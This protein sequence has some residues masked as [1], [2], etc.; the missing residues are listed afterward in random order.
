MGKYKLPV[1][2]LGFVV[3]TGALMGI[4]ALVPLALGLSLFIPALAY[5]VS[6]D[7][8]VSL[9]LGI[10]F[11][12]LGAVWFL[13]S[14]KIAMEIAS[15]PLFGILARIS[16][17][18]LKTEN[19]ILVLSFISFGMTVIEDFFVGLP[20]EVQTLTWFLKLKWGLYFFSSVVISAIS[21]GIISVV[22]KEDFEFKKLKF[23]F[24]LILVFLVFGFLTIIGWNETLRLVAGNF[25]IGILGIFVVQG[26]SIFSHVLDRLSFWAK[27]LMFAAIVFFP[28]GAVITAALAGIFDFWFDFRKLNKEVGNGDHLT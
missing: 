1:F 8:G 17:G 15:F 12:G 28:V 3:L 9:A 26:F 27:L 10:S 20:E 14:W 16:K 24:W 13:E 5:L 4:E 25:L 22:S 23:N 21:V 19:L 6:R 11:F 18:K 2:Y 7:L